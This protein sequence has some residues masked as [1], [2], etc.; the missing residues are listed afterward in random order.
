MSIIYEC[1]LAF[2]EVAFLN[3][4][5]SPWVFPLQLVAWGLSACGFGPGLRERNE[6]P[7]AAAPDR[8]VNPSHN[9]SYGSES[10]QRVTPNLPL[11]R[12]RLV[13]RP[14]QD[15]EIPIHTHCPA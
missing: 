13:R 3:Q 2:N 1:G 7:R 11:A 15:S 9:S 4:S 5:G 10:S 8:S 12:G 14:H 6:R